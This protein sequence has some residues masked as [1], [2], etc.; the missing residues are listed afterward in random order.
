MNQPTESDRIVDRYHRRD[1]AVDAGRYSP[2]EWASL[3]ANQERQRAIVRVLREAFRGDLAQRTLVD[4]GCGSGQ[5]LLEF[6]RLGFAPENLCGVDLLEERI[7][8][9][10]HRLSPRVRLLAG[11][12]DTLARA[13]RLGPVDLAYFGV[14]FSSIL[15]DSAR[16][17]LAATTWSLVRPGGGVLLYDFAFDNPANPDVRRVTR[18]DVEALFPGGEVRSRW[19]TLAPPI[20][21]RVVRV[22]PALYGLLD[23]IP[24]LRSHRL[25]WIARGP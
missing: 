20:A 1:A 7:E 18:K 21:R 4:I 12:A 2:L 15:D 5:N 23:A 22:H 19:I 13:S 8:V 6:L 9:A 17:A 16:R 11:D 3:L 24:L 10:R 25:Y 14:V